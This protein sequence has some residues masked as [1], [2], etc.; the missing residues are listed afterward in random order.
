MKD[1]VTEM[2]EKNNATSPKPSGSVSGGAQSGPNV[3]QHK[4]MAAGV[5]PKVGGGP[6][7]PA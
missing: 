3:P 7:T 2:A 5:M 6:K 4:R 1:G